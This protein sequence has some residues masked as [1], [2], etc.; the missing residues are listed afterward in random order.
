LID[1]WLISKRKKARNRM[2]FLKIII[3]LFFNM[4]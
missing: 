1:G 4:K 2:K 3:N